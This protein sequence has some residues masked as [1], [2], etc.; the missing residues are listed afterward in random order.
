MF[1]M[2]RPLNEFRDKRYMSVNEFVVVE[3]LDI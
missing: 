3:F 1:A 2:A